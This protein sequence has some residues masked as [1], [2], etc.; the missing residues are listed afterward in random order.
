MDLYEFALLA[1]VSAEVEQ[2]V[3]AWVC[4]SAYEPVWESDDDA[5]QVD[6][7]LAWVFAADEL[8]CELAWVFAADELVW[9]RVDGGGVVGVWVDGGTLVCH[10]ALW[11]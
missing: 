3:W 6:D 1:W 9:V 8:V 2:T 7:E 11:E 10:G 4:A 5:V